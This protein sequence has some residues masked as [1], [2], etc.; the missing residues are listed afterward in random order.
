MKKMNLSF[1]MELFYTAFLGV[2]IVLFFGLG[3]AAFYPSP[4]SPEPP[5]YVSEPVKTAEV[6]VESP[7]DKAA[8]LKYDADQKKYNEDFK[9][10]SRNVSVIT[11]VL[12]VVTLV[13][14]IFV[15]HKI[16]LI[17]DGLLLG[18]VFTLGY[19]IIRGLMTEDVKFRFVVTTIGLVIT[20][21]VGYFKF[22]KPRNEN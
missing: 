6:S 8:R 18:A 16:F 9:V 1:F 3:V 22:I 5:V 14:S 12:A 2:I 13:A 20:V 11:M 19:S 21:A 10:Y 15:V 7:A 17:S 4:K